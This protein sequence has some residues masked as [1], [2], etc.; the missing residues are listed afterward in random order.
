MSDWLDTSGKEQHPQARQSTTWARDA[1]NLEGQNPINKLPPCTARTSCTQTP[2]S[3]K[4]V[5]QQ[6]P[7]CTCYP[8]KQCP[9]EVTEMDCAQ[10]NAQSEQIKPAWRLLLS[11]NTSS[12]AKVVV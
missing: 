7:H 3:N 1:D 8:Q 4:L 12:L 9:G 10:V 6:H 11:T 5:D 2:V